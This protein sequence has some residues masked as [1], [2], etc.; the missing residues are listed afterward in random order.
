MTKILW[1]INFF[2]GG[3]TLE[4]LNVK[5]FNWLISTEIDQNR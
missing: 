1:F 3:S 2:K 5:M 4:D